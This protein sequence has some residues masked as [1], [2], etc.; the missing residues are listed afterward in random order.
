MFIYIYAYTYIHSSSFLTKGYVTITLTLTLRFNVLARQ[1]VL[2]NFAFA[3]PLSLYINIYI[4]VDG[5]QLGFFLLDGWVGVNV[6][7]YAYVVVGGGI[8]G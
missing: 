7:K 1:Y 3:L 4:M 6:C 5:K 8:D 2:W